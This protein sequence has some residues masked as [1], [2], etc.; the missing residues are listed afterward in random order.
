MKFYNGSSWN[1][2]AVVSKLVSRPT[3]VV[4]FGTVNGMDYSHIEVTRGPIPEMLTNHYVATPTIGPAP[5]VDTLRNMINKVG[6]SVLFN[7]SGYGGSRSWG[8]AIVEGVLYQ[9]IQT[10]PRG[11][12]VLGFFADG[13]TKKYYGARGDTGA[14]MVAEGI[15]EAFSFGCFLVEDGVPRDVDNDPVF[16]TFATIS[17]R[18]ILGVTEDGRVMLTTVQGVSGSSGLTG[19]ATSN[20]AKDLGYYDAIMLDGGGSA[21][22]AINGNVVMP[23]SD[24]DER[25]TVT[26]GELRVDIAKVSTGWIDVPLNSGILSYAENRTLKIKKEDG[27]VKL[28]GAVKLS[29]GS[30]EAGTWRAISMLPK[31]FVADFGGSTVGYQPAVG[32]AGESVS[33]SISTNGSIQVKPTATVSLIDLSGVSFDSLY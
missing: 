28:S 32:T 25:A 21:Q 26:Y 12:E 2:T 20:F 30:F 10:G 31:L 13:T 15:Q 11:S 9:E 33:V 19:T 8:P 6:G 7:S 22:T 14:Q 1:E 24:A 5:E 4:N 29:T 3:A 23:S 27:V 16:N 17:A 18:Q